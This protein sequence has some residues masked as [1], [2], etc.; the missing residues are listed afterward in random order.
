MSDLGGGSLSGQG[1][2]T[3]PQQPA[4][5]PSTRYTLFTGPN[6]IRAGWRLLI[7]SAMVSGPILVLSLMAKYLTAGQPQPH[8]QASGVSPLLVGIGEL[9]TFGYLVLVTGIL[10]LI[11]NRSYAHYGLPW[12]TPFPKNFW[13]GLFW[14]FVS[15]SLLLGGI[16][17]L[18]GFQID[19]F[20]THGRA[21]LVAGLEWGFAFL[22][23]GFFEE[24][25]FRGYALFTLTTGIKFPLAAV[26]CSALFAYVHADNP[27]ESKFGLAQVFVFGIFACLVIR[28]TGNMWWPIGFHAAWDWG[29]TY[30]YGVPDSGLPAS[31]ALLKTEFHGPTWLTGGATGP[32]A[33]VLCL[34]TLIIATLAVLWRYKTVKYPDPTALGPRP[35]GLGE[36]S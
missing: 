24:F 15:I 32:E 6:G 22:M 12:R 13:V 8:P 19:G 17:A 26:V 35:R 27:G 1:E 25:T 5:E 2:S 11:E 31:S 30:F 20:A 36:K 10:G 28:R 3:P 23:V 18:H 9:M 33:S 4:A 34:V 21:A 16:G 14:G 29:Q 7:F